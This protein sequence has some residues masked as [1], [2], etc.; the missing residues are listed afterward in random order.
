MGEGAK[1]TLT[2]E[3]IVEPT[4]G[5]ISSATSFYEINLEVKTVF[6]IADDDIH[7]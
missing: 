2:E 6:F 4:L 3:L 5:P 1:R 7:Q